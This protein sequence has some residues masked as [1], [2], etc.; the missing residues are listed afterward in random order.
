MPLI[1]YWHCMPAASLTIGNRGTWPLLFPYSLSGKKLSTHMKIMGVSGMGK[2]Y[3]IAKAAADLI[4]QG[5]SVS[6]ID[7]HH[8][9]A[10]DTLRLLFERGYFT[11][12]HAYKKLWY[13]DFA[14]PDRFAPFNVLKQ[15]SY[16]LYT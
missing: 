12:P 13:I 15:P 3:F 11:H 10:H 1:Y 2:S 4:S 7:P 14:R 5:V 6:L 8:D 16:P 9:L